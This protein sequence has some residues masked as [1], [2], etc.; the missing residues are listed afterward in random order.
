[1]RLGIQ[2]RPLMSCLAPGL[3]LC[4][5]ACQEA[6]DFT[7]PAGPVAD[8]VYLNGKVITVDDA[9]TEATA[10]ATKDGRILYVGDAAGAASF[11]DESRTA[12]VDLAG[13]TMVPG[14]VDAHGHV[15][16]AGL[17]AASANLLPQPD[18]NVNSF[19]EL[20][21]AMC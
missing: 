1:M 2:L 3:L 14:F 10:V 12:Q 9:Q 5:V 6:E 13:R 21:D 4:L 8:A 18:G 11:I 15:V 17:Q 20:I 16:S 7:V 19:A